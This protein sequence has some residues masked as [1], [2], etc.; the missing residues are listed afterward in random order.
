MNNFITGSQDCVACGV[1]G[2]P[3]M[4]A[5]LAIIRSTTIDLTACMTASRDS[6]PC[7]VAAVRMS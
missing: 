3:K 2:H 6:F 5:T 7:D 4:V 1:P